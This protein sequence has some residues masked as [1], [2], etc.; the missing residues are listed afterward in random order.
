MMKTLGLDRTYC[1]I[2]RG[3]FGSRHITLG[4]VS[5]L[6]PDPHKSGAFPKP[7]PG[8]EL[9]GSQKFPPPPL[10]RYKC[11]HEPCGRVTTGTRQRPYSDNML[12]RAHKYKGELCPGNTMLATL[13]AVPG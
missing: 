8:A 5:G 7:C 12:P 2:C 10:L 4:K 9:P 3:R 6:F 13:V 11:A 1:V